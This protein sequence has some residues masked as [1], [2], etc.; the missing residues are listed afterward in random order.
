[1]R[2]LLLADKKNNKKQ[3]QKTTTRDVKVF[4]IYKVAMATHWHHQINYGLAFYVAIGNNKIRKRQNPNAKQ[5]TACSI[6]NTKKTNIR[7]QQALQVRKERAS[8]SFTLQHIEVH[9]VHCKVEV[10]EYKQQ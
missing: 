2:L 4:D 9:H 6:R 7:T 10:L 5:I 8:T 3:Q 1:M